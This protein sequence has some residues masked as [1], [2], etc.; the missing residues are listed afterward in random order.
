LSLRMYPF[1]LHSNDVPRGVRL[2]FAPKTSL[3]VL[4]L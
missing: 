1:K 2:S 4:K 3:F